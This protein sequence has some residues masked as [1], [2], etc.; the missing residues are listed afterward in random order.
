MFVFLL[1][2][3]TNLGIEQSKAVPAGLTTWFRGTSCPTGWIETVAL[4]DWAGRMVVSV[5]SSDLTGV[6]PSNVPPLGDQEDRTHSHSWATYVDL[7]IRD[8]SAIG[9]C[10]DESAHSGQYLVQGQTDPATA[11]YLYAQLLLCTSL[12]ST[13][14]DDAPFGTVAYFLGNTSSSCPSG[15]AAESQASGRVIVGSEADGIVSASSNTPIVSGQSAGLHAHFF[16]TSFD[17]ADQEFSGVA[18]CCNS[19]PSGTSTVEVSGDS[20]NADPELPYVQ[21]LTCT[22]QATPASSTSVPDTALLFNLIKC[23]DGFSFAGN[24][25]GR[26]LF[27]AANT[28]TTD[29][30]FGSGSLV[31]S[32]NPSPPHLHAFSGSFSPPSAGV[33]LVAGCCTGGYAHTQT[34]TFNGITDNGEVALPLLLLPLCTRT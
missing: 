31:T 24:Y 29:V 14:L 10:D 6:M 33:G 34:Y 12:T 3:F 9:C 27:A 19:G 7:P 21:L 2:L 23:P 25:S 20:N 17:T 18:G 15:W 11:G 4:N 5:T 1:F 26:L 30:F 22:Q 28:S 8:V 13:T 16:S 32:T